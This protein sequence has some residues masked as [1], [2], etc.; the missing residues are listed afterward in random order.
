MGAEFIPVMGDGTGGMYAVEHDTVRLMAGEVES[1]R[2][3]LSEA[4]EQLGY[5]I[6]NENPLQ[7]RRNGQ[8]W[9]GELSS[10]NILDCRSRLL[11]G[12]K[13]VG[14]HTARLTFAYSITATQLL[15]SDRV[16]LEKEVD[17]IVALAGAQAWSR[18]CP[19]CGTEIV[20]GSRFCRQCG[21]P[22]NQKPPAEVEI[23]TLTAHAGAA[24][25]GV[26]VGTIFMLIGITLALLIFLFDPESA[27]FFKRA[28]L[29][30]S[31]GGIFGLLGLSMILLGLRRLSKIFHSPNEASEREVFPTM[32]E[33]PALGAPNTASLPPPSIT[34]ATTEMFEKSRSEREVHKPLSS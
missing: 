5:R 18:N 11:V 25:K 13:Q 21:A 34:E 9:G 19:A 7:A 27:K 2:G 4:L 12:L 24:Y 33:Q 1:L 10:N 29:F 23:M 3:H 28:V 26:S 20:A 31:M 32:R 6:M 16:T 15:K 17:A 14:A 8:G 30:G 22:R